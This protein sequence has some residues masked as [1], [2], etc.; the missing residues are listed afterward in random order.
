MSEDGLYWVVYHLVAMEYARDRYNTEIK[1]IREQFQKRMIS[2]TLD[3]TYLKRVIKEVLK[4]GKWYVDKIEYHKEKALLHIPDDKR[5]QWEMDLR[6]KENWS[7]KN[8]FIEENKQHKHKPVTI[9]YVSGDMLVEECKIC[10]MRR[11]VS[12]SSTWTSK[13]LDKTD[14]MAKEIYNNIWGI[15]WNETKWDKSKKG[16]K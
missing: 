13:W 2:G 5:K 16:D 15:L 7:Y 11:L 10:G 14:E 9:G 1:A 8:I 4:W 12:G 6:E 3:N